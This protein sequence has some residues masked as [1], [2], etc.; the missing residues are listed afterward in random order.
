MNIVDL[1]GTLEPGPSWYGDEVPP[2][3][4]KSIGS[5]DKDHY[6]SH[7]ITLSTIS[8][9]YL[10]T[11]AHLLPGEITIDQVPL[12]D[13]IC[14]AAVIKTPEKQ[15]GET[16]TRE[17][18]KGLE[19]IYK[20][21]DAVLIGTGWDR[22]WGENYFFSKSPYFSSDAQD[23]LLSLKIKILGSDIVSYDCP[24][25][26]HMPF[27][28]EFFSQKGLIATPLVNITAISEKRVKFIALP[29]KLKG[30]TGSPCRAI[31]IEN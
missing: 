21:G 22:A 17:D 24:E 19:D 5:Y 16:I 13:I 2:T 15:H 9:T 28:M 14:M 25:E 12:K 10:E 23:Y 27:L 26:T 31:A 4:F 18:L 11:G 29:L 8:G 3:I 20:P 1:T 7:V 6:L 30:L